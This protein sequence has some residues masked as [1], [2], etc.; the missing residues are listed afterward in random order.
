MLRLM[1][2]DE[3]SDLL[4]RLPDLVH[5]QERRSVDFAQNTRAWL[6]SLE[7]AFI[8]N[9]LHQAGSIAMLRTGLVAAEQGQLPAGYEFRGRPTRLRVLNVVA[10]QALQR[11]T[12]IASVV[13]T[14]NQARI[15]EAERVARQ[16]V[17]VAVSRKLILERAET[18]D[19]TQYL[20]ML[21]R[22][23]VTNAD[24]E[25]AVAHLEGLVG[26]QDALILL[27][28]ALAAYLD[29]TTR[30]SPPAAIPP[31]LTE[32]TEAGDAATWVHRT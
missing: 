21:R 16:I 30:V 23:M 6:S 12:E 8:A 7:K 17:A 14:E 31:P 25:S 27:D 1:Q 18:V 13:I 29:V 10:S 20:Q 22:G 24:L 9:R 5:Q 4:L 32:N 11:A 19:N 15:A 2:I 3:I 26:P 28:R